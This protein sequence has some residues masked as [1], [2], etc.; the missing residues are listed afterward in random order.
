LRFPTV[1]VEYV[2]RP[3]QHPRVRTCFAAF[4]DEFFRKGM[5]DNKASTKAG[6]L[7]FY[8]QHL[9]KRFGSKKLSDINK[10]AI[11]TLQTRGR[12]LQERYGTWVI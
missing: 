6:Y 3:G 1:A 8:Q 5:V 11:D 4:A 9:K 2:H 12:E 10:N 7:T